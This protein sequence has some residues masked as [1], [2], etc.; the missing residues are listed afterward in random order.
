MGNIYNGGGSAAFVKFYDSVTAP[1]AGAGT[2][3]YV[4]GVPAA[5]SVPI[6]GDGIGLGFANGI[7]F[8]IV[9]GAGDTYATGVTAGSV[10]VALGYS[11]G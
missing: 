8:T 5:A 4:V 1:T 2:P 11:G 6:P 7:G 9:A 10:V 3:V